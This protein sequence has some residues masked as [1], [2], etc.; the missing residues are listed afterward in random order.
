MDFQKTTIIDGVTVIDKTLLDKMQ[1]GIIE[2]IQK[3]E[4]NPGGGEGATVNI[5]VDNTLTKEGK[6]ADE[7][8]AGDAI[9]VL[10]QLIYGNP[11]SDD[12][13]YLDP[14]DGSVEPE[15]AD[16]E[17]IISN[18]TVSFTESTTLV[19]QVKLNSNPSSTVTLNFASSEITCT[20]SSMQFSASNW[21][22]YQS[23]TLSYTGSDLISN[24]SGVVSVTASGGDYQGLSETISVTV[25]AETDEPSIVIS[26]KNVSFKESAS[27]T[28]QISLGGKP[29]STVTMALSATNGVSVSPNSLTFS[30]TDY[31]TPKTVT[32]SYS[33]VDLESDQSATISVS[34]SG[35]TYEGMSDSIKVTV[36]AEVEAPSGDSYSTRDATVED[37]APSGWISNI[38]IGSDKIVTGSGSGSFPVLAVSG[39]GNTSLL[40]WEAADGNGAWLICGKASNGNFVGFGDISSGKCSFSGEFINASCTPQ[41]GFVPEVNER[42]TTGAGTKYRLIREDTTVR[43]YV[44]EGSTWVLKFETNL[45]TCGRFAAEKYATNVVGVLFGSSYM[46]I[47]NVKVLGE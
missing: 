33:G 23:L 9:N 35:S 18:T 45:D 40:E 44:F 11:E 12:P 13:Y 20:P 39:S 8:A 2:A 42:I 24:K 1:D 26:S 47:K 38:Q 34:A 46:Q 41:S 14:V 10:S 19:L 43:L 32:V 28:V 25:V 17:I 15:P 29:T 36:V 6:A 22:S 7:K 37:F 31:L 27:N 5:E 16:P 21:D 30:P 4:Q 3:A